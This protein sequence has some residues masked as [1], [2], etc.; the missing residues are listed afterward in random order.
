MLFPLL[1]LVGD[2]LAARPAWLRWS[3]AVL[4]VWLNHKVTHAFSIGAWAY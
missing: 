4:T 1:F 3:V 2:W